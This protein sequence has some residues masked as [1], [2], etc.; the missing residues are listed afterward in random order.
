MK[1]GKKGKKGK[2][3]VRV[4][5]GGTYLKFVSLFMNIYHV[6]GRGKGKKGMGETWGKK[7]S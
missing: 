4:K 3:A 1:K 5:K 6:W 2:K 7:S